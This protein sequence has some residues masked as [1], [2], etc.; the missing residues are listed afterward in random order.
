MTREE[1]AH[2]W[3]DWLRGI[4]LIAAAAALVG[5]YFLHLFSDPVYGG[6]LVTVLLTA[7]C[8][9]T[10]GFCLS[11]L[12][13]R[14]VRIAG[15][16]V[17]LAGACL[18]FAG[19]FQVLFP[20]DPYTSTT[21]SGSQRDG[22]LEIPTTGLETSYL[23]IRGRPGASPS[24]DDSEVKAEIEFR[25]REFNRL[26]RVEMY[27][28]R[29]TAPGK[30]KGVALGRRDS[31]LILL[32]GLPE[33]KLDLHLSLLKPETALPLEISLH[34]PVI[35]PGLLYLCL[36]VVVAASLVLGLLTARAG[37]FPFIVPYAVVLLVVLH[38]AHRGISP[39]Q[40]LLPLLGIVLGGGIAACA[41]GYGLGKLM[42]F[43]LRRR[44][45]PKQQVEEP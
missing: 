40:P 22:P 44:Q 43:A 41:A 7:G 21:L 10:A 28:D 45:S 30:G 11:G 1:F 13:P 31:Q 16:P 25:G 36:W 15:P 4:T 8:A 24:G 5:L 37:Q 19:I 9:V 33:G 32:D 34:R 27:G 12:M 23:K 38:F 39:E 42:Q 14:I 2:I 3:H 35:P 6:I 26:V 17:A 29:G 18:L 20:D